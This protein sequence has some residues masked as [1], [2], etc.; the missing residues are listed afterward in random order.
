M[1]TRL[2]EADSTFPRTEYTSSRHSYFC[3]ST[4]FG[5]MDG[6]ATE[7]PQADEALGVAETARLRDQARASLSSAFDE[8]A[9]RRGTRNPCVTSAG[10][11]RRFYI[12]HGPDGSHGARASPRQSLT[13]GRR[14]HQTYST[15]AHHESG[16]G[17]PLPAPLDDLFRRLAAG[18]VSSLHLEFVALFF[19][20]LAGIH[21]LS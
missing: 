13:L 12:E 9:A 21:E 19:N 5:R 15:F 6:L 17:S 4:Y 14:Y 20:G 7:E 11:S 16:S 3:S 8:A 1:C 18:S 10:L 2:S